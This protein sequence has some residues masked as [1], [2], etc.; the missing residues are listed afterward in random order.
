VPWADIRSCEHSCS[1]LPEP[2]LPVVLIVAGTQVTASDLHLLYRRAF[3]RL[4][5]HAHLLAHDSSLP[6]GERVLQQGRLQ[7]SRAFSYLFNHRT[8]QTAR[9]LRPDLVILSGSNWYLLPETLRRL[10]REHGC[11]LVLNEQHLQIFRSHQAASLALYDHV[12]TQDSA[13]VRI[14]RAASAT[15]AISLLGPACDPGEHRP[16]ALGPPEREALGADVAY[17]GW[18]Y[19]NRLRLFEQ[20]LDFDFRLWGIGWEASPA[21]RP[22]HDPEP[23]HGLKKTKIYNAS[24]VLL[25]LQS[26]QYQVDG[27]TCRPF[28]VAACGSFCLSEPKK[29]LGRFFRI[30][31][32]VAVFD[33]PEDLR[34]KLEYYLHH[35]RE[36]LEI[37][38]R[39]RARVV[40]EHT[41]EHR[42]REMLDV[43]RLA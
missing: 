32:E 37:A 9:D 30:G 1:L 42:V 4:G 23:V 11:P 14:L 24:R 40:R 16:L 18:G 6:L 27:V 20:L 13:L 31:E 21:L 41:Y 26:T 43:L 38:A 35:D 28:E 19:P 3:E 8:L 33:G 12:F 15:R 36:R 10:K 2:L 34:T 22:R 17:V 5:W 25:N 39:G 7:S 29:D